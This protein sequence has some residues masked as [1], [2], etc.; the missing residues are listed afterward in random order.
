MINQFPCMRGSTQKFTVFDT[1]K[2]KASIEKNNPEL[3][4]KTIDRLAIAWLQVKADIQY[5]IKEN[6]EGRKAL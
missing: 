6:K 2:I 1:A 4:A 3:S 5:V